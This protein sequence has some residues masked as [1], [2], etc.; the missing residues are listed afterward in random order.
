MVEE[1][2]GDEQNCI[3]ATRRKFLKD[4]GIIASGASIAPITLLSACGIEEPARTTS[5]T[6]TR[7]T[8]TPIV[9]PKSAGH[10]ALVSRD[11][12]VCLSCGTS[13]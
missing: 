13:E 10:I 1:K 6:I 4:A 7:Y 11:V 3:G 5:V 2:A 9:L 12:S 8:E